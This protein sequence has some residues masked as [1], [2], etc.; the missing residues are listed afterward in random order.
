DCDSHLLKWDSRHI[1]W[2]IKY[3][4]TRRKKRTS[5]P[6]VIY[7]KQV[8]TNKPVIIYKKQVVIKKIYPKEK[9]VVYRTIKAKKTNIPYL[10]RSRFRV[11]PYFLHERI[12]NK[13]FSRGG[14]FNLNLRVNKLIGRK[15]YLQFEFE[16]DTLFLTYLTGGKFVGNNSILSILAGTSYVV[17]SK[18]YTLLGGVTGNFLVGNDGY[19]NKTWVTDI[20][21][22]I[23]GLARID[24][25]HFSGEF[26]G[27]AEGGKQKA[28]VSSPKFSTRLSLRLEL[29][30]ERV[31]F[32][33]TTRVYYNVLSI[34]NVVRDNVTVSNNIC[35]KVYTGNNLWAFACFAIEKHFGNLNSSLNLTPQIGVGYYF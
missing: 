2:G 21:G 30:L 18:R 14:G 19:A 34:E 17:N 32:V 29:H 23:I 13:Q 20:F 4:K 15:L 6:V 26:R 9:V 11:L 33:N 8:I 3:S 12:N 5:K 10:Q 28:V 24:T 7:K 22:G 16:N 35:G 27:T 25:K 31:D 1:Y